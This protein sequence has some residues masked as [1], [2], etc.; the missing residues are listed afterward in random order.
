MLEVMNSHQ[1]LHGN[2][3]RR[4]EERRRESEEDAAKSTEECAAEEK[5]NQ[6]AS[7]ELAISHSKT[8]WRTENVSVLESGL[9]F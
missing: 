2:R 8:C 4:D 5:S 1:L 7:E 6:C 3:R 9:H